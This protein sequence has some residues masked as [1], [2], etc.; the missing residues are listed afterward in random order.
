MYNEE[1][2]EKVEVIENAPKDEFLTL[3]QQIELKLTCQKL[4][5]ENRELKRKLKSAEVSKGAQGQAKR[6]K[7]KIEMN[8][9]EVDDDGNLLHKNM[10]AL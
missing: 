6:Q 3:E 10:D 5:D 4:M 2:N 9:N 8:A 1:D 7:K